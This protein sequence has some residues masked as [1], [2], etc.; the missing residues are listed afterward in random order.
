MRIVDL[1]YL[2]NIVTKIE[3]GVGGIRCAST[4]KLESYDYGNKLIFKSFYY[5]NRQIDLIIENIST[6]IPF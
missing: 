2:L 6:Y 5:K 3:S 4:R 1:E